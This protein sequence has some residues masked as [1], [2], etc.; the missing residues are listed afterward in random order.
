MVKTVVRNIRHLS[1]AEMEQWFESIGE[2][3]FRAKQVYEWIWQ[4]GA[5]SFADMTNLSK[6]LRQQLGENFSLPSLSVDVI[7]RSEDGTVKLRFKTWDAH[8][9]EGVLIPTESRLTACVS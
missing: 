4:K 6:A 9:V 7:Q 3:N 2:K 8:F 5:G 1:L